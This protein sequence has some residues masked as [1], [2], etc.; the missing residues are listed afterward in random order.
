M[1]AA[2]I[3]LRFVGDVKICPAQEPRLIRGE[4]FPAVLLSETIPLTEHQRVP[5]LLPRLGCGESECISQRYIDIDH[6]HSFDMRPYSE[7]QMS[8]N[9]PSSVFRYLRGVATVLIT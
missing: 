7:Y 8:S 4:Q 5:R 9:E 3:E 6:E 1:Y 2:K